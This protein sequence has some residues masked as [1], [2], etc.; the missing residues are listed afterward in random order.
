[1][2]VLLTAVAAAIR[3]GGVAVAR[4]LRML[5]GDQIGADD[6][7]IATTSAFDLPGHL[8]AKAGPA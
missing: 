7:N 8:A 4:R 2:R 3:T 5:E 6:V 1:M